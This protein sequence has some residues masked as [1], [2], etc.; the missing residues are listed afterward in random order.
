MADRLTDE[1]IAVI[2]RMLDNAVIHP[3]W[4]YTEA[5]VDLLAE[6]E[7]LKKENNAIAATLQKLCEQGMEREA[8]LTRLRSWQARALD[9]LP[10][11]GTVCQCQGEGDCP[12]KILRREAAARAAKEKVNG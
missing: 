11:C 4:Q 2:R 7:W 1:R 9:W 8:E 12:L 10:E 6:V 3:T 5:L